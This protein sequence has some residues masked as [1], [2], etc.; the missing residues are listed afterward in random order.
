MAGGPSTP[1]LAAAVSEAGALGSISA[2]YRSPAE[3][4]ADIRAVREQTDAPF[5]LNLLI[6]TPAEAAPVT[7]ERYCEGL[8]SEADRYRVELGEPRS[9]DDQR[10][11]KVAMAADERVA[12]VSFAFGCPSLEEVEALHERGSAVWVT[13]TTPEEAREAAGAGADALVVQGGE[14]GGHRGSFE[15]RDGHGETP[16]L[17]LLRLVAREV[18]VPLV[19]AGGI[20]DGAGIAA[21]LAGGATAAQLGTAFLCCPEAGTNPAHR[22]A[23][24]T[25]EATALTR[26][27]TGRRARGLVNRFLREHG[28]DAPAAYPAVH[29]LTAPVRGA[30]REAGD[31]DAMNLWAGEGFRLVRQLPAGELVGVLAEELRR[32]VEALKL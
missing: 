5:G 31:A 25:A 1:G 19:A 30:A 24:L 12:V 21:V 16:L 6:A 4:R 23:L 32:A 11:E 9:D 28:G 2:G 13:V 20:M 26:A 27:F 15:D 14:A 17:P 22:E 7:L 29:H 18:E 10:S 3:V 8:R